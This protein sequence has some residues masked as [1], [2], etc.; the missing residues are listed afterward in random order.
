MPGMTANIQIITARRHDSLKVP[1]SALR[2][3]P[4]TDDGRPPN[5]NLETGASSPPP[6]ETLEAGE[7]LQQLAAALHLS[8]SQQNQIGAVRAEARE[9]LSALRRRGAGPDE[10]R[11]E[12]NTLRERSRRTIAELLSPEQ[13]EKFGRLSASHESNPTTRGKVYV[14]DADGRPVAVELVLGLSDGVFTE[15]VSGELKPGQ[16]VI[17][18]THSP[19]LKPPGRTSNRLGFL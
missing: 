14:P 13:R 18:G 5:P 12:T 6:S 2:F 15:V 1:N 7:R 8:E 17:I 9:K 16:Q 19:A 4:A 11:S 3:R 10:I